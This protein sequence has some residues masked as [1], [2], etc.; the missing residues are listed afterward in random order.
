MWMITYRQ[1]IRTSPLKTNFSDLVQ[2]VVDNI[3]EI[4]IAISNILNFAIAG[5]TINFVF[6][7]IT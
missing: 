5:S 4:N 6:Q 1:P 2:F 3:I 7:K